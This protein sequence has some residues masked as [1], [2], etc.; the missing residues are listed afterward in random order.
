MPVI[1]INNPLRITIPRLEGCWLQT[2]S[3]G[4]TLNMNFPGITL[5]ELRCFSAGVHQISLYVST[6][7]PTIP[8]ILLEFTTK[9][10]GPVEGSFNARSQYPEFLDRFM[11][12][13]SPA[14]M[15]MYLT[16]MGNIKGI[17]PVH[18]TRDITD[19]FKQ[20]VNDQLSFPYTDQEFALAK[21]EI[22]QRYS[23]NQ[24]YTM[25]HPSTENIS[26]RP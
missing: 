17:A 9:G 4:L 26:V 2:D 24:L 14:R 21:L 6:T 15:T 22:Q 18:L 10:F 12:S 20:A 13:P 3:T 8:F 23:S 7:Q 19:R 25:G 11:A 1:N 5:E 16:D